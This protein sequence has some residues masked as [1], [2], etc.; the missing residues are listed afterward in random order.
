MGRGLWEVRT[1]LPSK[2]I[3][4][5][6]ICF[7]HGRLVALQAF[8]KKTRATPEDDLALARKRQKELER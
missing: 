3:A 8:I 5:V 6:L 7:S 1:E 4:R 2:R